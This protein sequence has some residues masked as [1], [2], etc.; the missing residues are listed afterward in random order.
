MFYC[1]NLNFSTDIYAVA[2]GQD[3]SLIAGSVINTGELSAPEGNITVAAVPGEKVVRISQEGH[4]LSL[5]VEP[6]RD[7]NG[8]LLITMSSRLQTM[9]MVAILP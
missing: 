3:L 4:L 8:Q 6:P 2:T 5:E 1:I 7:I 9:V